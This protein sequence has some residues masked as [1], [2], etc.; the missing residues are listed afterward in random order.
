MTTQ[1][2]ASIAIRSARRPLPS[3]TSHSAIASARNGQLLPV[4][5]VAGDARFLRDQVVAA[6]RKAS[7]GNGIAAFNEDRFTA[8]EVDVDKVISAA[9]TVPMMAPRRFVLVRGVER[10]EGSGDEDA[11]KETPLDRLAAYA[12]EPVDSTCVVLTATKLDGRRKLAS[13][14]KRQGFLVM[15]DVLARQELPRWIL[16][17]FK[18]RGNPCEP[19]VADLLAEI[20]G[21]ELAYVNDAVERL[22][23]HAGL[24][25]PVTE[26]D[27]SECIARV[28]TADTWALVDAVRAREL[29]TALKNLADVYDPR[30]RGLPLLGALAWSIRQLARFKAGID[31]GLREDDAAKAMQFFFYDKATF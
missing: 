14:A 11:K 18:E 19:D 29:G 13:V 12:A 5:I 1:P 24:G 23:L 27:V 16:E 3:G 22:A 26:S 15:C 4:Y 17:R 9:R 28:R 31:A 20:A 30:D 25:E 7:L 10:W 8:G 6:L 21:P 2:L